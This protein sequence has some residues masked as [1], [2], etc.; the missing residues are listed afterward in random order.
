MHRVVIPI[1]KSGST[2]KGG[3]VSGPGMVHQGSCARSLRWIDQIPHVRGER[4]LRSLLTST[5]VGQGS[6]KSIEKRYGETWV[7]IGVNH[8]RTQNTKPQ[9]RPNSR[10]GTRQSCTIRHTWHLWMAYLPAIRH[11][12]AQSGYAWMHVLYA[13]PLLPHIGQP[14]LEFCHIVLSL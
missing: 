6:D 10:I 8:K 9:C 13:L 11:Y 14:F 7:T 3:A 12:N 1:A 4:C 5:T 2:Y